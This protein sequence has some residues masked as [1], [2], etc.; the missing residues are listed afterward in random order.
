MSQVSFIAIGSTTHAFDMNQRFMWL[1]FT[2]T[3]G[4]I[5][6]TPPSSGSAAPPGYYMLFILNAKGVPSKAK[7]IRLR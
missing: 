2:R 7:V 6:V 1:T 5:T 3:S 4:A